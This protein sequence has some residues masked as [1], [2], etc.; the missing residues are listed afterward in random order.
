MAKPAKQHKQ[1]GEEY[2][3]DIR[4][5]I[6]HKFTCPTAAVWAVL[7]DGD[8]WCKWTDITKVTWH[9]EQ[10]FGVGTT[11]TVEVKD[12][13]IEET[14]FDWEEGYRMA[15]RFESSN[16]PF[17]SAGAE[18]YHLIE[19]NDGCELHWR[20]RISAA[21]PINLLLNWQ[22]KK[23]LRDGMLKLEALL[24]DNSDS[25]QVTTA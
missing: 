7:L 14:F 13:L 18:A 20:L 10:P 22:I 2:L 25:S 4:P 9:S 21:F 1:V 19:T 11:R 23:S 3:A 15:F 17:V 6:I 16:L 5:S 8:A 12:T 24:Q